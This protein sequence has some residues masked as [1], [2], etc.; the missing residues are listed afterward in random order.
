MCSK[1]QKL[2]GLFGRG[3]GHGGEAAATLGDFGKADP[4]GRVDSLVESGY[5][6]SE[7]LVVPRGY[8]ELFGGTC[9][10]ARAGA[11]CLAPGRQV[12]PQ[13]GY[14]PV[15]LRLGLRSW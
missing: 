8:L 5:R 6:K 3:V 4:E 1:S 15:G 9:W 10:R 11:R 7:A 2:R 12:L 13:E 14:H